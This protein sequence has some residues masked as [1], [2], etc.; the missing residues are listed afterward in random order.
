MKCLHDHAFCFS[1]GNDSLNKVPYKY[2]RKSLPVLY[3]LENLISTY[4]INVSLKKFHILKKS[5]PNC[6]IFIKV[7]LGSEEYRSILFF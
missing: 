6:R 2:T 3:Y 7:P 4:K 1:I 5:N